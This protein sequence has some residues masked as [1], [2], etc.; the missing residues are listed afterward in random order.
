MNISVN[1]SSRMYGGY[2]TGE[3]T[4][5]L[6]YDEIGLER[7][8]NSEE[9]IIEEDVLTKSLIHNA[10]FLNDM[11]RAIMGMRVNKAVK[12]SSGGIIASHRE[13]I[14]TLH[15]KAI[16][17][18]WPSVLD[19]NSNVA[20]AIYNIVKEHWRKEIVL[21]TKKAKGINII[22]NIEYA[23]DNMSQFG[24]K[25]CLDTVTARKL[26]ECLILAADGKIDLDTRTFEVKE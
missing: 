6:N 11:R 21:R 26:A 3:A 2:N 18:N 15:I 17:D 23:P 13:T 24:G 12:D 22:V 14:A 5:T 16:I 9:F 20:K 4:I 1:M 7:F 8:D 10:C 19:D 25:L